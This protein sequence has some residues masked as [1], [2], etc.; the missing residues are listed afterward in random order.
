[1]WK[2]LLG[3]MI[4]CF[5]PATVNAAELLFSYSGSVNSAVQLNGASDLLGGSAPIKVGDSIAAKFTL[6]PEVVSLGGCQSFG[7]GMSCT[8][9]ATLKNYSLSVGNYSRNLGEIR[10]AFYL[11]NDIFGQ[12]GIGFAFTEGAPGPFGSSLTGI[13]LQGRYSGNIL[14][15][16]SFSALLPFELADWSLF[17]FF[18]GPDGRVDFRGP[19]ALDVSSL[20]AVPEPATWVM[21]ILGFGFIG[22]A[23]RF[24]SRGSGQR[25][26]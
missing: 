21:M 8:Y 4:A 20:T 15:S 12:D 11:Q 5:L 17:A 6:D 7:G 9:D 1:M 2:S 3:F 16:P 14:T 18:S 25:Q 10:V 24:Q 23:M 19:L 22:G 26:V 13:Q